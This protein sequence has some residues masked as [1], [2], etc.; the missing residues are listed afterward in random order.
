MHIYESNILKYENEG[1][2]KN[3]YKLSDSMHVQIYISILLFITT[4]LL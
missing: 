4:C 2:I 1:N 3:Q